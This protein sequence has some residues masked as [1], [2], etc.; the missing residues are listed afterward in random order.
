MPCQNCG[1]RRYNPPTLEILYNGKS[2]GDVMDMT[3]EQAV[4][5]FSAHPKIQRPLGPTP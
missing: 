2:I 5:F 1:G 4:E 3:I